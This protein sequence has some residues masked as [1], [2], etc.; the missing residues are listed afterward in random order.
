MRDLIDSFKIHVTC[1]NGAKRAFLVESFYDD[2]SAAPWEE[3]D[4]HG[5]VSDWTARDKRPGELVLCSDGTKRRYYD[6]N[7]ARKIALMDG[8]TISGNRQD[9]DKAVKKDF[10]YLRSWCDGSWYYICIKVTPLTREG[11]QLESLSKHLCGLGSD[12]EDYIVQ[13]AHELAESISAGMGK[14]Y[15]TEA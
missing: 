10:D 13:C 15:R 4:G 6:A 7:E 11:D 14:I 9:I 2:D 5:P 8:W 3:E 12:G 1:G